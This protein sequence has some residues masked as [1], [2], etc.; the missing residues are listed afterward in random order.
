MEVNPIV[1]DGT[2]AVEMVTL[3]SDEDTNK[4]MNEPIMSKSIP[5]K[6]NTDRPTLK[7]REGKTYT[8]L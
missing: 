8:F 3:Q 6:I 2:A 5:L 7:K 4:D 1:T